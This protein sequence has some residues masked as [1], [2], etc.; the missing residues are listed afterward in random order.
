[1]TSEIPHNR[2]KSVDWGLAYLFIFALY[3]EKLIFWYELQ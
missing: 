3:R 2:Y 1:M